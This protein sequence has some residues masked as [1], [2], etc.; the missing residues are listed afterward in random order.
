MHEGYCAFT[1]AVEHLGDRWSFLIVRELARAGM[2]G[3]SDLA[4][5][6]PGHISRS[7]L[8]A[9]LRKLEQLGLIGREAPVTRQSRY[10]LAPAGEQL[11][12]TL[13]S[14]WAW[15]EH[16]VPED[17]AMVE[18][19]PTVIAAWLQHRARGDLGPDR[20]VVVELNVRGVFAAPVWLLLAR[21]TDPSICLEDPLLDE[22]RY[23]Y[24]EAEPSAI[25]MIAR[26]II[27]WETA[28]ADGSVRIDGEPSLVR[29]LP[30]WF[31]PVEAD[32]KTS[33]EAAAV[34]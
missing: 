6:I 18:R 8:A 32:A 34:A 9:R 23:L 29:Q 27:G 24:V 22:E 16:W 2:L 20:P 10:R 33:P 1:K 13:M 11:V 19:D 7:V 15:A 30:D 14:L 5:G 4:N 21:D 26:G 17:P 31:L 12:P 3:F 28:T 25:Y